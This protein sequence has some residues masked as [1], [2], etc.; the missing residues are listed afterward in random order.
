MEPTRQENL[1]RALKDIGCISWFRY[2]TLQNNNENQNVSTDCI[3]CNNEN[4]FQE[5]LKLYSITCRYT[6]K[7]KSLNPYIKKAVIE[8]LD[9]YLPVEIIDIIISKCEKV[10]NTFHVLDLDKQ[11]IYHLHKCF[12]CCRAVINDLHFMCCAQHNIPFIS[13][14]VLSYPHIGGFYPR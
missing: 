5:F 13:K 9:K 10:S 2:Q 8:S 12:N 7:R 3:L 6:C 4:T 14:C 1:L 11:D